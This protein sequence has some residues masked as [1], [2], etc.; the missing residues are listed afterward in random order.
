MFSLEFRLETAHKVSFKGEGSMPYEFVWV[1]GGG[2]VVLKENLE[3]HFG[4]FDKYF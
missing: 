2:W 3:L 1:M 4:P